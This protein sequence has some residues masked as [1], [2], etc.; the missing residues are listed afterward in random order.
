MPPCAVSGSRHLHRG[1]R[2][3][4][5]DLRLGG[6]FIDGTRDTLAYNYFP[7]H[8]DMVIDTS[9]SW[10][11]DLSNNSQR[12]VNTFTHEHGHGLGLE[13]VCP[14][15]NTKLL[16]P[17]INTGFRGMQFDEIYTLQ[18]WYG[19]P[20]EQHGNARDN[21]TIQR[22]YELDVAA[23]SPFSFHW[24]SID[25]NT[26]IDYFALSIPAGAQLTARIIPSSAVYLEGEEGARGCSAEGRAAET[27][28]LSGSGGG[29]GAPL[30]PLCHGGGGA[31]GSGGD[32]PS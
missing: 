17:F 1:Q 7:D 18:R 15:D 12:L 11:E 19:D 23:G 21:D 29:G 28:A 6:H 4:R 27:A 20:F 10:F 25:D 31:S 14:I 9:D 24:L 5:G 3:I 8:G 26:D 2:G 13:H 22:A 32:F 16:E 30:H